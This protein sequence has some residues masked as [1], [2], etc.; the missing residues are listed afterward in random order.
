MGMGMGMV[1]GDRNDGNSYNCIEEWERGMEDGERGTGN[2]ERGTGNGERGTG[3][4]KNL[5]FLLTRMTE[6]FD[7]IHFTL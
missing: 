7:K 6:A 3:K 2:G 5:Y 4:L 1:I